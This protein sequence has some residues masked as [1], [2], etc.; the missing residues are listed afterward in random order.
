[1]RDI[2]IIKM[3]IGESSAGW[4]K[5]KPFYVPIKNWLIFKLARLAPVGPNKF[6]YKLMGMRIGKNVQIMPCFNADIFFPE[7]VSI[8]EGTV[9]GIDALFTCHEFNP[10]EF[11]YGKIT[12]GKNVLIG[13]RAFILPGVTIGDNA[14]VSAQTLVYKDVPANV[15]AFGSPLQF[16]ERGIKTNSVKLKKK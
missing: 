13:A 14:L 2:K 5:V 15:I 8:G 16:K 6:F 1:M 11:R 9:I 12:I 7:K 10:T 3:P 4:M